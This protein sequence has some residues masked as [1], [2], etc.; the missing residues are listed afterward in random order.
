MY[1]TGTHKSESHTK[2][3]QTNKHSHN[4][5]TCKFYTFLTI[6]IETTQSCGHSFFFYECVPV[7]SLFFALL[8]VTCRVRWRNLAAPLGHTAN[9]A[10]SHHIPQWGSRRGQAYGNL[11]QSR[12]MKGGRR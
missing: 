12:R 5:L 10:A 7:S 6:N 4:I 3:R 2:H 1:D 8:A 9:I 11:L